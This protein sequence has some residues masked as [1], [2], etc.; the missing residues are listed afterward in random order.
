[1]DLLDSEPER[2]R[3][4]RSATERF[5]RDFDADIV[6]SRLFHF[7]MGTRPPAPSKEATTKPYSL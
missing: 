1:M 5:H 3:A 4:A 2:L 7:V 6:A